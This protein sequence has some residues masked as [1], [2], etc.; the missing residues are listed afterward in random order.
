MTTKTR[1]WLAYIHM[2]SLTFL[3]FGRHGQFLLYHTYVMQCNQWFLQQRPTA[4]LVYPCCTIIGS[5]PCLH[6]MCGKLPMAPSWLYLHNCSPFML[7][8]SNYSSLLHCSTDI[9]LALKAL[10]MLS[11]HL[12]YGL[13]LSLAPIISDLVILL[14]SL[15]MHMLSKCSMLC[16]FNQLFDNTSFPSHFQIPHLIHTC[17]CKNTLQTPHLFYIWSL[18]CFHTSCFSWLPK[19]RIF[20][21]WFQAYT[22]SIKEP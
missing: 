18:C 16:S 5:S 4:K 13:P 1:C 3:L 12:I 21:I 2:H 17:Y 20:M 9:P 22:V 14:H 10:F 19:A 15:C 7:F 6:L 11:I 8:I